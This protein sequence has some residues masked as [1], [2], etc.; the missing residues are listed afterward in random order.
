MTSSI[1]IVSR[2]AVSKMGFLQYDDTQ[3]KDSRKTAL[4]IT[5]MSRATP[6]IITLIQHNKTQNND[7]QYKDTQ[8]NNSMKM[9]NAE[10]RLC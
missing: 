6:S 4:S 2:A 8:H 7:S 9:A 1:T 5:T 10:C 3:N